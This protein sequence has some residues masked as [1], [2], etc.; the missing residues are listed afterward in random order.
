MS[1]AKETRPGA[2]T[3]RRA[4]ENGTVCKTPQLS[5]K[6][7]T[8]SAAK[9][10]IGPIADLLLPGVENAI[11]RKHLIEL[12]G[13]P[14]RELRRMIEAERRR[15]IPILSDNIH[16]YFLPGSEEELKRWRN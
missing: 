12:T 6:D 14:D 11:P 1:G 16:G 4:A 3:P 8:T 15:G 7:S 13:L 10:Q 2:A 9:R 5:V